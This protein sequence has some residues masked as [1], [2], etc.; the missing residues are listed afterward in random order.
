M[1]LPIVGTVVLFRILL[2]PI[3]MASTMLDLWLARIPIVFVQYLRS[4]IPVLTPV[5]VV[6]LAVLIARTLETRLLGMEEKKK[7]V[8]LVVLA[9]LA[10]SPWQLQIKAKSEIVGW[11]ES[12]EHGRE[13][14]Q[15]QQQ[16]GGY[17]PP[18][19]RSSNPT[20]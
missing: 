14:M 6:S 11:D 15:L 18:T 16:G 10:L 9:V 17:S 1:W 2:L 7:G 12:S 4:P 20:P 3:E 8:V 13:E 5:V 19:A